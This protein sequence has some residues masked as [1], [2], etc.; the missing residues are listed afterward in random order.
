MG[1]T[2]AGGKEV[3]PSIAFLT[4]KKSGFQKTRRRGSRRV[5]LRVECRNQGKFL[6]GGRRQGQGKPYICRQNTGPDLFCNKGKRRVFI[7]V[8]RSKTKDKSG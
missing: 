4:G 6:H 1:K 7:P 2:K 3:L 5:F 8:I